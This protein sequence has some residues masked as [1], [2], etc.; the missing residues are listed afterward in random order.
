MA[1]IL[2][3]YARTST[4]EQ[5]VGFDAQ[6]RELTATGCTKVFKEQVS[7]VAAR[8]QLDAALDY[9]REGDTLVV[10]KLDRLARSSKHL[11][12]G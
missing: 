3:G 6:V 10:S 4:R 1:G 9:V 11:G 5:V 12:E 2:V 8:A 7:S